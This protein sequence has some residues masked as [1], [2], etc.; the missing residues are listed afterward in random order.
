MARHPMSSADAAWLHMD[1]PTNLMVINGVLWF[2]E[3]V[4]WARLREVVRERLVEPFPRFRQHVAEGAFGVAPA[5][6]D[7][8]AFDLD[9]HFHRVALPVPGDR[10]A[11]EAFVADRMVVPLERSRPLWEFHLIDGY[12]EGAAVL[13]R[14]HHAIADGIA[15]ARVLLSLTDRRLDDDGLAPEAVDGGHGGFGGPLGPLLGAARAGAGAARA[16]AGAA[17]HEGLEVLAHPAHTLDLLATA[18]DD[19]AALAKVLIARPDADTVLK[20]E[21][22]VAE[23]VTWCD[24][25]P[26]DDVRAIARAH[27]ATVN[28]VLVAA[29]T[30]ALRAY[31]E[32]RG[33]LV[34]EIHATVPFNLRA[35]D[36]PLPR[37]LGN[38]FGLV[39]LPL[40]VGAV[41]AAERLAGV[42]RGMAKIKRSPEGAISYGVL[43][44]VGLTPTQ[45]E[46]RLVDL[47]S[48]V[49]SMVLTNV[50]G[51]RETVYLAGSPVRGVLVWAPVA[52]GMA[53][54]IA[55]LSYAGE[56]AIGVMT[57]AGLVPDPERIVEA[58]VAEFDVLRA[59]AP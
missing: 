25:V 49:G 28:D 37:D 7:D 57:D 6:E 47:F 46:T 12:G 55:I 56:V 54:S 48:A 4:D 58:F 23:R 42:M 32:E 44:L 31:L 3:P 17:L 10:A 45:V 15:L 38:R 39:T 30:G 36:E 51:P 40:P 9:L 59:L 14:M 24:P 35:L 53:M 13:A 43:G 11:L 29:L 18:R 26:L 16:L 52:G 8:R 1:R 41:G 19:A 2:D 20:G 22:G 50:P 5:W 27:A 33:S 21:L 34:D